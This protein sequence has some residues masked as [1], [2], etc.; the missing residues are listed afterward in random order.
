[1]SDPNAF[2][3]AEAEAERLEELAGEWIEIVPVQDNDGRVRV[4]VFTR[5]QFEV[6][7]SD[8]GRQIV[9]E[10]RRTLDAFEAKVNQPRLA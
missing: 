7:A 4:R 9:R 6:G 2:E 5:A 3:R 1:M 10:L 8:M